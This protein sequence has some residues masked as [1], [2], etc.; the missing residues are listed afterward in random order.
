MLTKA[1]AR[2]VAWWDCWE[3]GW[4]MV[5]SA[6]FGIAAVATIALFSGCARPG[7]SWF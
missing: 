2:I 4:R 5:I 7:S 1:D 3:G 6:L